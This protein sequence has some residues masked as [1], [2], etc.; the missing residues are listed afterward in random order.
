MSIAYWRG[1]APAKNHALEVD[2][3]NYQKISCFSLTGIPDFASGRFKPMEHLDASSRVSFVVSL[4]KSLL[5]NLANFSQLQVDLH[6]QNIR[7]GYSLRI[8]YSP[9]KSS[10]NSFTTQVYLLSRIAGSDQSLVAEAI[11]AQALSLDS[12]LKTQLYKFEKTSLENAIPEWIK[13]EKAIHCYE[14]FKKEEVFSWLEQEGRFFYSPGLFQ[15][16]KANNM[17][18]FF[19]QL[20][21]YKESI[22][23]DLTLVPTDLQD[24]EKKTVS[25]YI[26][27]L[28]LANRGDREEE[29]D[30]D[31]NSQRAK[32]VYEDVKKRYYSGSTFL[33]SFRVFTQDKSIGQSVA[34]QL[35]STCTS[36]TNSPRVVE[37]QD[38]AYAIKT[39]SEVNI[40]EKI[41]V[42]NLW[43]LNQ[44]RM[45]GFS[46]APETLRR[47][48]RIVD[49]DEAAAFFRLPVPIN[50]QCAGMPYDSGTTFKSESRSTRTL[51][52]GNH[53]RDRETNE[54]CEFDLE[55]LKKH[56]LIVGGSG[57]GKTT[58]TFNI[59]TQ[60]WG[61]H[62][63]PF[64]VFDPKVTPEYR[65]LKRLPE[66]QD[67]LLIFTPGREDL[68]PFRMN[69]F[70]V[71]DGVS[72]QEHISR[73]FDCFM[74]ALPLE[75][76]LPSFMQEA[77][78]WNYESRKWD[79][80]YSKGGDLVEEKSNALLQQTS[81]EI[82]SM[83]DLYAKV[84]NLAQ[85]NYGSDKEVGDRV[86]GA[87]KARLYR[88]T[89]NS[90]VGAMLDANRPFPLNELVVF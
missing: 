74:G 35:A 71:L 40:N 20:Q 60:L 31:S 83:D 22:C 29:I 12:S 51:N 2:A 85:K 39:L 5:K 32:S 21:S 16:N 33:Y 15:V 11:E 47:L 53:Y 36:H 1:S 18:E 68:V 54:P 48:H 34:S 42:S 44:P 13:H 66:F 46:G 88:L 45:D 65:Y 8:I 17:I 62:K 78:D 90:G 69:P 27:A 80:M 89:A 38:T 19:E 28:N 84:L 25:K 4:Q 63:I 70:E 49:L 10:N 76:P 56:M 59:L 37:V 50:Q 41:S 81:L 75:D 7:C 87:L 55:E 3:F 14:I 72:V 6:N 24:Y 61:K 86:K 52:L 26:E 9:N 73:L 23:V 77:I 64:M 79:L 58:T 43:Q 57:S 67:N 30:P 82:P